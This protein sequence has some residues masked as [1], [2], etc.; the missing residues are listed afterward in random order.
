MVK[1]SRR[2]LIVESHTDN[3]EALRLILDGLGHQVECA[4]TCAG[5]VVV[6][7]T[8]HPDIV[9]LDL[10]LPDIPGEQVAETMKRLPLP[11]FIVGF[12]GFHTR[13]KAARQSGCDA[14]VLKPNLVGLLALVRAEVALLAHAER[15]A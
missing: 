2:I 7:T 11:P 10:G 6:T 8:W 12:S 5:A 14:F 3:R 4:R 1:V 15:S 9:V 13:A